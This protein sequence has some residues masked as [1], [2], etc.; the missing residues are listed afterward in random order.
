MKYNLIRC[1]EIKSVWTEEESNGQCR[2]IH[3]LNACG[4]ATDTRTTQ[5]YSNCGLLVIRNS[6][7]KREHEREILLSTLYKISVDVHVL[8]TN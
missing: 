2:W 6:D 1:K 4:M 5:N 3:F 8:S 7:K